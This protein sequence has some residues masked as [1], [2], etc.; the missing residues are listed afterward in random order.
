MSGSPAERRLLRADVIITVLFIATV[1]WGIAI[2]FKNHQ[3]GVRQKEASNAETAAET[4]RA[5]LA[6]ARF[7]STW[8]ADESWEH[9]V[10]PSNNDAPA[11]SLDVEHALVNGHPIIIIGEI[12]DV[13][14]GQDQNSPLVLIQSHA[15]KNLVDLRFSL[16]TTPQLANTILSI[17][18]RDPMAE[19]ETF[20]FVATIQRVEKIE[21]PPDKA[22]NSQDYFLAHGTLQDAYDTHLFLVEPKELGEN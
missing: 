12:Q 10:F 3:Q 8:N 20:I 19:V 17:T 4:K 2:W 16:A 22:D 14:T 15:S 21:Q 13:R 7:R 9:Q 11:Y 5:K 18:H 6:L 1:S